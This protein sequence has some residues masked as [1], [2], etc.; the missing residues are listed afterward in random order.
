MNEASVGRFQRPPERRGKEAAKP[1][2]QI[3]FSP[4]GPFDASAVSCRA[5]C[6]SQTCEPCRASPAARRDGH[7]RDGAARVIRSVVV[8]QIVNIGVRSE[9]FRAIVKIHANHE[10]PGLGRTIDGYTRHQFSVDLECRRPIGRGLLDAGQ[11]E[12]DFPHG[13]E[14]Y[15]HAADLASVGAV[16][17][18][19][20]FV[21][22]RK[23]AR[24]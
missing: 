17:D 13:I 16:C 3:V 19:A 15:W 8:C 6:G 21:D 18:R 22:S 10:R 24:S 4:I 23:S 9:Q 20:Y 7:A 2:C 5:H 14:S 12:G 1:I 11:C